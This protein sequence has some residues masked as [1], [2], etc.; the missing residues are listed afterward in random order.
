[1]RIAVIGAGLTGVTTA[2]ELSNRGHEVVVFERRSGI[3]AEGSH[4]LPGVAARGLWLA[5]AAV[6]SPTG[7]PAPVGRGQ[8]LWQWRRRRAAQHPALA[9]RLAAQEALDTVGAARR[10]TWQAACELTYD[11]HTGVVAVLR[12][13]ADAERARALLDAHGDRLRGARW[14]DAAALATA[15]PGLAPAVDVQGA[16]HW[17]AGEAA[18]GRQFAHAVKSAA[19]GLGARFACQMDVTALAPTGTGGWRVTRQRLADEADSGLASRQP[20]TALPDEDEDDSLPFDA[21]VL[22]SRAA[23]SRLV[24]GGRASGAWAAASQATVTVPLRDV[25]H[26]SEAVGPHGAWMDPLTRVTLHRMGDRVRAAG[27]WQLGATRGARPDAD[28]VQPLFAALEQAYPGATRTARA[29]LWLGSTMLPVDGLPV[30]GPGPQAGLWL[31]HGLGER[32]WSWSPATSAAMADLLEGRP[33][34]GI[35]VALLAPERLR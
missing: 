15:D 24:P 34:D 26:A 13:P 14:V 19:Q 21:V 3:A 11:R 23:V 8:W 32:A 35:D 1:M 31:H 27:P 33:A 9:Q 22:C 25:Q 28:A 29:Q 12:R 17:P 6:G 18:N 2:F 10:A 30:V 16:L 7:L 20:L 4:A 5:H